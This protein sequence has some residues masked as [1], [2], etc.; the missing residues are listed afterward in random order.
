MDDTLFLIT[1]RGGSK[2]I[3]NKNI[4]SLGGKP[5]INYSIEYARN[6]VSD[7]F[8]CLSTDSESI[9]N[10]A[11]KTGLE[12]PFLRPSELAT[13]EATSNDVILH[14]LKHYNNKINLKKVVLLQPTSPFRLKEHLQRA[15]NI[16]DDFEKTDMV[17]GV[18][19]TK[20]NPYQ[21]LFEENKNGFLQKVLNSSNYSR[22]QDFP[23]VFEINGAI[24]V[25]K[26]DSLLGKPI[27]EFEDV[28]Y[29]E[30]PALNS[31]DIDYPIDWQWAEFLLKNN[32]I[33]FDYE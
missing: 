12:V 19:T 14:A 11:R 24:Y 22:R 5:L 16:F 20:T 18:K 4:K 13:D 17:V 3:P 25:Y 26:V 31:V 10:E 6:F 32:L 30:M 7:A 1:A 9:A 29:L 27:A 28:R 8:I 23:K 33:E 2:G 21:V 15:L